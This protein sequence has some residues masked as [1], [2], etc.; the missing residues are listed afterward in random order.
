MR[1][2]SVLEHVYPPPATHIRKRRLERPAPL[3]RRGPREAL[4]DSAKDLTR[5]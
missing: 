4:F 1:F 3:A 5:R 2:S